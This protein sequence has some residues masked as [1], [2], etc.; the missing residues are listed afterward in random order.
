MELHVTHCWSR[1]SGKCEEQIEVLFEEAADSIVHDSA[2]SN[3][4][5]SSGCTEERVID[6]FLAEQPDCRGNCN[7][8]QFGTAHIYQ[9]PEDIVKFRT[10]KNPDQK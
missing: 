2:H 4:P 8:V 5:N 1:V 9:T 3:Q 7:G 6:D 10:F